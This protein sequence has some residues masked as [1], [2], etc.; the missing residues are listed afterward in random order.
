VRQALRSLLRH[1]AFTIAAVL[2]LAIA[3]A[4][5]SL[6]F[7]VVRSTLL[8]SLPFPDSD[9][10]V[11][12]WE[13]HPMLGK[14]EIAPPDFRDWRD[15]NRSF[16]RLAAYTTSSYFE[17]LLGG[18]EPEKIGVTLASRDLLPVLGVHPALGRNFLEAEDEGGQ[19]AVAL[20]SDRLWRR[21]FHADPNLVGQSLDLNGQPY[22]IVGVLPPQTRIPEWADVWLPLSRL[23]ADTASRRVSHVLIGIGRLKPGVPLERASVDIGTIVE[24]LRREFPVSNGPT[25]FEMRPLQAELTGD[26]RS[27]L[28]VLMAAVG[29]V[30]LIASAN[31]ANLLLTRSAARQREIATR[32]ALGATGLAL[33]RQ[34]VV[35]SG[36]ISLFGSLAGLLLAAA[37][38]SLVRRLA[39]AVLPHPE[40]IAVEW[41]TAAFAL[42]LAVLTAAI[43]ALAPSIELLRSNSQLNLRGAGMSPAQRRWQSV[44]MTAQVAIAVAVLIGAGLLVQSFRFLM[45]SDP[46]FQP[47]RLLSFRIALSPTEYPTDAAARSYYDRL[48]A[49]LQSLPGVTAAATVNTPPF[50]PPTR[51]G[52]R[53]YV[54]VL[55]DPGP[56]NFPVAQIRVVSPGY[57]RA[58]GIPLQQGRYLRDADEET[59]NVVVNATLARR[60]FR[61]ASPV[62]HNVVVGLLGPRR[63]LRPIVGVV[64]DTKDTG[65]PNEA[66]PTFYF[67][68]R[69]TEA[70]VLV[71]AT[72][73]PTALLSAVE[74]E[75]HALDPKQTVSDAASLQELMGDSVRNQ[76][77]SMIVFGLLAAIALVLAAI[78]TYGVVAHQTQ[79][80]IPELGIRIALGARDADVYRAVVLAGLPPVLI[81]I[82]AGTAVGLAFTRLMQGMLF[83]IQAL[84]TATYLVTGLLMASV[85]LTAMAV[86]AR[87]ATKIDP[88]SALRVG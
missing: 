31:V 63:I 3:I 71:R 10:V 80:R 81:G 40:R 26:V 50:S 27:P 39:A 87:R 53:F 46:G 34:F 9:R 88:V 69:T 52:G 51:G 79:H 61:N 14:Q 42:A 58:M 29:L 45:N 41:Q 60:F 43:A 77:F 74:R 44:F 12:L 28:T 23:D 76:R 24:S 2:T 37:A 62:G 5:N 30:L 83:G 16:E 78:G 67:I 20:V 6:L 57:F 68:A 72:S 19:N 17:P 49:R 35:E 15:W 21:R 8:Q 18:P 13:H 4:A 55:P 82:V 48:L 86:P 47:E 56:G 22:T 70:T 36:L 7:C 54:D 25:T 65:L 33:V 59:R 11:S 32:R 85:A 64:A 75:V 38:I 1:P 73:T 84:D 66:W